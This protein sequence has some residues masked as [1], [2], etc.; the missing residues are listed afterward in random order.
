[1]GHIIDKNQGLPMSLQAY[2]QQ[3]HVIP[4]PGGPSHAGGP[5]VAAAA[6]AGRICNE[7]GDPGQD[8]PATAQDGS[9]PRL[10][11]RRDGVVIAQ[12]VQH[13]VQVRQLAGDGPEIS[14]GRPHGPDKAGDGERRRGNRREKDVD[15]PREGRWI[16]HAGGKGRKRFSLAGMHTRLIVLLSRLIQ[17][18]KVGLVSMEMEMNGIAA[19][20][21]D[22]EA[23]F[24]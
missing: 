9:H 20:Q 4:V 11:L 10:H 23:E 8:Y 19:K 15:R 12:K 6:T 14:P 17:T 7:G 2:R 5:V 3:R 13:H 16:V 21:R 24:S 1:M 22:Q 18:I